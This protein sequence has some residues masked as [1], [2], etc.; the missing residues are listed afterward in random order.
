MIFDKK[1][2]FVTQFGFRGLK[3]EN[4]F[5]PDDIAIDSNDRIYVTQGRNRGISV[6][7]L[8]HS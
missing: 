4:L 1:H 8:S 2:N 7:K 6:F 5:A 3:P